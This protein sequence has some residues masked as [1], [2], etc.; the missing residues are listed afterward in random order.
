MAYTCSAIQVSFL[1]PA[2]ITL[3]HL[4]VSCHSELIL[5][6]ILIDRMTGLAL[7]V[8]LIFAGMVGTNSELEVL[9]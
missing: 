9:I 8:G 2:C 7:A 5:D 3:S 6:R 4:F 1:H